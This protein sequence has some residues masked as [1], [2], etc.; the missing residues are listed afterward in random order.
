MKNKLFLI[1]L[2]SVLLS[3]SAC[4]VS[5]VSDVQ[6]PRWFNVEVFENTS[7]IGMTV[8][9]FE[10]EKQFLDIENNAIKLTNCI[11]VLAFG[12]H[13]ISERSFTNWDLLKTN[14]EA[15][16]RYY[17]A[18]NSALSYWPSKWDY[19]LLTTFAS[20]VIPYIG[21]DN[22]VSDSKRLSDANIELI[23][24]GKYNI[25][26]SYDNMIIEYNLLAKADFNLDGNQDLFIRMDWYIEGAHGEGNDWIVVSKLSPQSLPITLWRK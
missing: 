9:D 18:P 10:F 12:S 17:K 16:N 2:L 3:L 13:N 14:C 25:K 6:E 19:S 24:S 15:V 5:V 21:G 20:D 1:G 26:V 22:L 4:Q 8:Y 7:T 23:D 11:D